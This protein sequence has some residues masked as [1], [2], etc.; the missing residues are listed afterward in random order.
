MISGYVSGPVGFLV[1]SC[2]A[3]LTEAGF[4]WGD[5]TSDSKSI[6][7]GWHAYRDRNR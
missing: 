5:N 1:N 4:K 2:A 6:V 3:S 7:E